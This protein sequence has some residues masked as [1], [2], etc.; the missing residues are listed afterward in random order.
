MPLASSATMTSQSLS[1]TL[2][3]KERYSAGVWS[4]RRKVSS[5]YDAKNTAA[6]ASAAP[7]V[8]CRRLSVIL[9]IDCGPRLRSRA[10]LAQPSNLRR[11]CDDPWRPPA[12]RVGRACLHRRH[13]RGLCFLQCGG[14]R[15]TPFPGG[16]LERH[17]VFVVGLRGNQL[18]RECELCPLCGDRLAAPRTRPGYLGAPGIPPGSPKP[19]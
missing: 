3:T 4:I 11:P 13:R 18:H 14:E 10:D 15:E 1:M 12:H 5:R 6:I 17:L 8:D 9:R 2:A 7:M 16:Q 19:A